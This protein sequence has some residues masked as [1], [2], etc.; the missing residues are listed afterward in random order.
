MRKTFF[1]ASILFFAITTILTLYAS[2]QQQ[3]TQ[4]CGS[5]ADRAR[6]LA[7]QLD[8]FIEQCRQN[9]MRGDTNCSISILNSSTRYTILDARDF[10]QRLRKFADRMDAFDRQF[11]PIQHD[12][13]V[14]NQGTYKSNGVL[15]CQKDPSLYLAGD[16]VDQCKMQC[17]RTYGVPLMDCWRD[18]GMDVRLMGICFDNNGLGLM[19]C[20]KKCEQP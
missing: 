17:Y 10:A 12:F 2:A 8:V 7:A 11:K 18:D 15:R 6:R 13:E 9:Q 3:K 19:L 5:E 14:D 20:N 16:T 4:Q 1:A